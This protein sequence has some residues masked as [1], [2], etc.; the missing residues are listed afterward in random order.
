[1][2]GMV[3]DSVGVNTCSGITMFTTKCNIMSQ[4]NFGAPQRGE[5]GEGG[6]K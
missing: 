6:L 2:I 3:M 1:M 5:R 4:H